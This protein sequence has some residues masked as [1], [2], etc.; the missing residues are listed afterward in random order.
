MNE[1]LIKNWNEV[2]MPEDQIF[3]LGD[4]GFGSAD[5]LE[6]I[7]LRL[8]GKK[9][10]IHGN[11][12]QTILK[13]QERFIG[14]GKFEWI[15]PY[16]ELNA[17][18]QKIVLCHYPI[19]SWNGIM[20]NSWMLYGHCHDTLS[21]LNKGIRRIDVGVDNKEFDGYRP[22]SLKEIEKKFEGLF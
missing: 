6:N 13:H 20:K 18:G 1:T 16:Y 12:D 8:N 14:E 4:F 7:L 10:L 19:L 11:H 22:I 5:Y 9:Y 21:E 3:H 17:N 15:K 2:V